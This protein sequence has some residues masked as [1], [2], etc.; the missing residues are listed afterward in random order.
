LDDFYGMIAA[1]ARLRPVLDAP[2]PPGVSAQVRRAADREFV[3][4]LN[5]SSAPKTVNA[6]PENQRVLQ[7]YEAWTFERP[8]S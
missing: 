5:F 1:E 8:L 7:P 6:G 3:F 4:V 2:L